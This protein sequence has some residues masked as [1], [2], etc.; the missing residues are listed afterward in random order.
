MNTFGMDI[1]VAKYAL[2]ETEYRGISEAVEFI[3]GSENVDEG[4]VNH[5]FFGYTPSNYQSLEMVDQETG[6]IS[7]HCFVCEK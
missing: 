4:A 2:I 7:Q 5:R 3:Y 1:L 6:E